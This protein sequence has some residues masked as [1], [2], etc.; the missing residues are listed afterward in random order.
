MRSIA[1]LCLLGA[2]LDAAT[3]FYIYS[4]PSKKVEDPTVANFVSFGFAFS[5]PEGA[6]DRKPGL[7][8][9]P[10][11]F[12]KHAPPVSSSPVMMPYNGP[13]ADLFPKTGTVRVKRHVKHLHDK[14]LKNRRSEG[15]TKAK[16]TNDY[17]IVTAATPSQTNSA[18]IDEDGTDFSYFSQVE[19]GSGGDTLY[20]LIDTGSGDSWTM[21][22]SCQS[23][24]CQSH[25][26]F[27][28]A[29]STTFQETSQTFAI[30]YGSGSVSGTVASD[31]VELAGLK[32]NLTF[33]SANVTSDQFDNYPMDGIL[34]LGRPKQSQIGAKM[35]MQLVAEAS[36]LPANLFGIHLERMADGTANGEINFGAPDTSKY[37][38][39]LNYVDCLSNQENWEIPADDII[40]NGNACGATGYTAIFDTGT[41][42]M[43]IPPDAASKLFAGIPGSQCT[44]EM[45]NVPCNTTTPVQLS[46]GNV[47]YD[48]SPLDYVGPS[49]G[50]DM[51]QSHIIAYAAAGDSTWLL[52]DTFLKNVYTVYDSDNNSI[53]ACP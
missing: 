8:Q 26:T 34:A 30:A 7:P 28:P 15:A 21:S 52:G 33:G 12:K 31:A 40:V 20:M 45:Y 29:D 11:K 27:G 24:A 13:K 46:F 4:P 36:L 51:C 35:F 1:G 44:G 37:V 50:G 17:K 3:A 53:G 2:L 9:S 23:S 6:T 25:N 47:S 22:S 49:V 43:L 14:W 48:V 32:V 39:S 10:L 19:F 18:A 41:S 16:R 5:G 38:G 42:Y